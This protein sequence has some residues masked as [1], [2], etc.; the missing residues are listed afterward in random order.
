MAN[1]TAADETAVQVA[2]VRKMAYS[3]LK[4]KVAL[5]STTPYAR[6]RRSYYAET[7]IAGV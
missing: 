6:V 5:P 3:L 7:E 1:Y 2:Q 4:I